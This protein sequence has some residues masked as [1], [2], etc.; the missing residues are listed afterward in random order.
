M[1]HQHVGLLDD[2][3]GVRARGAEEEVGGDRP[4]GCE[5]G[6]HERLERVE[7]GELLVE[8]AGGV[9]AVDERVGEVEPASALGCVDV[10][11]GV[12]SAARRRFQRAM[13]FVYALSSTRSWYSS[14]PITPRMC[15]LPIVVE[16]DARGPPA[17]GLHEQLA[18]RAGGERAVAGPVGVVRGR[19]RDV[20][21]D[22]LL[23]LAGAGRRVSPR[24]SRADGGVTSSP[25]AATPTG[26][27]RP[28]RPSACAASSAAGQPS[29]PVLE[30]RA[31]RRGMGRREERQHVHVAVPEDVA[32]VRADR[33]SPR[34]PTAASPSSAT[35]AIRWKSARRTAS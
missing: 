1:E 33:V 26:S 20:G 30:H 24:R 16:L 18:A 13:T 9:V 7:A 34:A 6:D 19:P 28:L 21:H 29:Q 2:L 14:G 17:R 32:A 27:A 4:L 12:A 31:R 8:P 11:V 23:E 10:P 15:P 5:L 25:E 22:V 35:D 3:R